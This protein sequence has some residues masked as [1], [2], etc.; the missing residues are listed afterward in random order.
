M[1]RVRYDNRRSREKEA[2]FLSLLRGGRIVAWIDGTVTLDGAPI[3]THGNGRGYVLAR[4]LCGRKRLSIMFH[5]LVWLAFH[6]PIPAGREI[7][8][9]NGDKLDNSLANLELTDRHGNL[10]HANRTGL[11]DQAAINR[12]RW[13]RDRG[14]TTI[15]NERMVREIRERAA[16]GELHRDI[17][18][19]YGIARGTVASVKRRQSWAH[20]E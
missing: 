20:V 16:K 8:H 12:R 13:A 5:C 6:G 2:A 17:A 3:P 15:L 4:V 14:V 11:R 19:D 9:R 10:A 18:A 7:N 1:P